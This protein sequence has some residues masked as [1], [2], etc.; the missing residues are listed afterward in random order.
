MLP[1][2]YV[3]PAMTVRPSSV[4][5]FHKQFLNDVDEIKLRWGLRVYVLK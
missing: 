4:I 3:L 1:L 2:M 5:T